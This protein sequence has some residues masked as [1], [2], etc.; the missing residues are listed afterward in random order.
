MKA[1][2]IYVAELCGCTVAEMTSLSRRRN[3]VNARKICMV[4]LREFTRA[5][6]IEI[7]AFLNRDHSTTLHSIKMARQHYKNEKDFRAIMDAVYDGCRDGYLSLPFAPPV[8][9]M[10]GL[11]SEE[12]LL[13]CQLT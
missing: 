12:E 7:G 9:E 2:E 4:A 13:I 10:G 11:L 6:S 3:A 8:E 1:L 5:S